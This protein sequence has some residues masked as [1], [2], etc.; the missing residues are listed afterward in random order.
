MKV[1]IITITNG[2]NYG[3]RLQNY[4]VQEALKDSGIEAETIHKITNVFDA[5]NHNYIRKL[6]LKKILHYHLTVEERR[7]LNFY[8]FTKRYIKKAPFVIDNAIPQG[9]ENAYDYFIAGSDQ[10]WNLACN[11]NDTHY[12]LDFIDEK[13]CRC[14]SYAASMST[15]AFS[16]QIEELYGYDINVTQDENGAVLLTI[17]DSMYEILVNA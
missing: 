16:N 1:G 12:F 4:A 14:Y 11:G 13:K 9:L 15:I 7:R 5:E 6:K 3:N 2:E 17:G 10:V 8:R